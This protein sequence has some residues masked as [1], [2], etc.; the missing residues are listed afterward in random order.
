MLPSQAL[1]ELA[2]AVAFSE[3]MEPVATRFTATALVKRDWELDGAA[4]VAWK[5]KQTGKT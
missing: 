2:C 3:D 5:S 4:D 1:D